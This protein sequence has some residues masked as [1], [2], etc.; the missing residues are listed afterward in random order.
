LL[1]NI[2][3]LTSD[4]LIRAWVN[5]R[6]RGHNNIDAALADVINAAEDAHAVLISKKGVR[7]NCRAQDSIALV[8]RAAASGSGAQMQWMQS[9]HIPSITTGMSASSA[10]SAAGSCF[11]P[12][13]ADDFQ[14]SFFL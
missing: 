11:E 9:R 4:D 5:R 2:S 8:Q 3:P 1:L 10:S 12:T 14:V 6:H 7:Q 13:S